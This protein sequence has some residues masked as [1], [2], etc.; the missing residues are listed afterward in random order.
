MYGTSTI[1]HARYIYAWNSIPF[2]QNT[3]LLLTPYQDRKHRHTDGTRTQ[4]VIPTQ[5]ATERVFYWRKFRG[6]G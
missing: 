3:I 4:T 6:E 5:A 1:D 2:D